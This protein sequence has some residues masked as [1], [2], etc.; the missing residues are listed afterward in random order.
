MLRALATLTLASALYGFSVGSAHDL[1]YAT[2]NLIKFPL[3]ILTTAAV[4]TLAYYVFGRA[5]SATLKLATIEALVIQLFRDLSVL[6][7]SLA[8]PNYFIAMILVHTDDGR[9]G[10]YSMF[11][12]MN[13]LFVAVCGTLA[14]LRQGRSLLA[15]CDVSKGRAAVIITGWLSLSLFVGGQAAFYLRPL[16]GLPASRG[17]VPPFALGTTPDVRGATNFYEAVYQVFSEP[18][19]PRSWGGPGPERR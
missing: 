2:R 8:V 14:V 7:A 18:P 16:I 5:L 3:L 15:A 12:G 1:I 19:L 4:C 9:L 13:V 17:N 10:E 11:L 6:L